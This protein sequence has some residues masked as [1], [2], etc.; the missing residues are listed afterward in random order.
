MSDGL[1]A[2]A[3][4]KR[5]PWRGRKRV[6]D[7]RDV[8]VPVRCT[9]RERA[10]IRAAAEEAGL[11]VGA[12]LRALALGDPGPRAVRK[13]P[14]EFTVLT[15]LLGQIGKIGG[16]INQ[17]AHGF[18]R[19]GMIPSFPEWLAMRR[20]IGEMR[21]ALLKALGRDNQR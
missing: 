2:R 12:F 19:T 4:K 6:K 14:V 7:S 21:N 9:Y 11:S 20:D 16:N 13:P 17:F 3:K 8:T 1:L 18:N 5:A 15:Q 10:A